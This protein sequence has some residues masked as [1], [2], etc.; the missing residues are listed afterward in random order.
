MFNKSKR[1]QQNKKAFK[2]GLTPLQ[3]A[4]M[5]EIAFKQAK[6][7]EDRATKKAFLLMLAIP[8]NV[9]ISDYWPKA[10]PTKTNK[11]IDEVLSLYEAWEHDIVTTEQLNDFLFEYGGV[12]VEDIQEASNRD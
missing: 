2:Q 8:L 7:M 4:Q 11:F 3:V 1:V 6:E 12:K 10:K 5:R 9:L